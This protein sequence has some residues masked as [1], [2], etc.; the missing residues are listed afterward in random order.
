MRETGTA[1]DQPRALRNTSSRSL[2]SDTL[3][4][5][6]LAHTL[7]DKKMSSYNLAASMKATIRRRWKLRE[8]RKRGAGVD[9][10]SLCKITAPVA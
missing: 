5:P 8:C 2:I 7:L 9:E 3:M 10:Q 4:P 6:I 1:A